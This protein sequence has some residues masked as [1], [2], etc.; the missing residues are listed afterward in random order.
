MI[1]S[2]NLLYDNNINYISIKLGYVFIL[3]QYCIL[4]EKNLQHIYLIHM[5]ANRSEKISS[6]HERMPHQPRWKIKHHI[7]ASGAPC[8]GYPDK[9][10]GRH[11]CMDDMVVLSPTL[12]NASPKSFAK[13]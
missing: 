3:E 11:P 8:L 6:G 2:G 13:S 9:P 7:P 10:S 5:W 4:V 12:L 1:N